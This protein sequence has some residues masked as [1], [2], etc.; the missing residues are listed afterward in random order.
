VRPECFRSESRCRTADSGAHAPW[1]ARLVGKL[2]ASLWD[3][4]PISF[5]SPDRFGRRRERSRTPHQRHPSGGSNGREHIFCGNDRGDVSSV[6]LS[7]REFRGRSVGLMDH[8]QRLA[9]RRGEITKWSRRFRL[10]CDPFRV[11]PKSQSPRAFCTVVIGPLNRLENV[12]SKGSRVPQGSDWKKHR[13]AWRR[14]S[15]PECSR[16]SSLPD[17]RETMLSFLTCSRLIQM[18]HSNNGS[19]LRVSSRGLANALPFKCNLKLLL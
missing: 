13:S 10:R 15:R 14:P 18:T 4:V 19:S 16:I 8:R 11:W 6:L 3:S 1:S 2:T 12:T 7:G 5:Q 9:T 17:A